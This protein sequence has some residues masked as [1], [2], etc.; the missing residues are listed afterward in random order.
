MSF[1]K[2][3][4]ETRHERKCFDNED[5]AK[6]EVLWMLDKGYGRDIENS[7]NGKYLVFYCSSCKAYHIKPNF[8]SRPSPTCRD[9]N[10]RPKDEYKTEEDAE[11]CLKHMREKFNRGF[12]LHAY[13]C[14][15][16]GK[17]HLTHK[18]YRN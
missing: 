16:C 8:N 1:K 6:A 14:P 9:S 15:K 3:C 17:F 12:D 10:N 5:E 4:D 18:D 7:G 2:I 13:R 11:G